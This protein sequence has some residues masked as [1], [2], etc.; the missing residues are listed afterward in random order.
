MKAI[1]LVI[2]ASLIMAK[3]FSS[4]SE[5]TIP[6]K[7][8]HVT[9]FL[10][11]AQII[12]EAEA[13]LP[14]GKSVLTVTGIS[15]FMDESSIQVGGQGAFT[16]L[17]VN[18]R[19]DFIQTL[20]DSPEV[21][22]LKKQIEELER[23]NEDEKVALEILRERESFLVTNK[24]IGG[25]EEALNPE[26]FRILFDLY[27]KNID[28]VKS[29]ILQ[30]QRAIKENDIV[31]AR[32][33]QQLAEYQNRKETPKSEIQITVSAKSAVN[34]KFRISYLVNG[35]GWFPSYDIRVEKLG[36]P[37]TL[38]YKANVSQ[39]TGVEWKNVLLT[40]SSAT[41]NKSGNVPILYPYFLD[42]VQVFNDRAYRSEAAQSKKV[43]TLD[44]S[45]ELPMMTSLAPEMTVGDKQTS[46]EFN[47]LV[48]YTIPSDSKSTSIDMQSFS[49]PSDFRYKAVPRLDPE[50]FLMA[51][52][53]D[54]EQYDL[55][56]GEA[57][58]YFENTFVGT[59]YIDTRS[60][61]DTLELSLG[62]DMGVVVKREKRKDFTSQRFFGNNKVETLSWEIS[63][64]NTKNEKIVI[65][66]TDQVPVSQQKDI[67][68]DVQELSGGKLDKDKGFVTWR[69]EL[70]AGQV[71][72]LVLTYEVRYPRDRVVVVE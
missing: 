27:G 36:D 49:L 26:S 19:R 13:S 23:K 22:E 16:I 28:L 38:V 43:M 10:Q 24:N 15:P 21:K 50:A 8:T 9:V 44:E 29:G 46:V 6:S 12:Q 2:A 58:L 1:T 62:R 5:K 51:R 63:V 47:M 48:P 72:N 57:N 18:Q 4:P 17:S 64:R 67:V 35:A 39:N 68:V 32:L 42:F 53:F 14:A 60:V 54:W 25:K 59:S 45:I 37:V 55:L 7:I 34:A 31:L 41:P 30:K 56:N 65:E 33:R 71:V 69:L 3:G 52:V 70:E 11:G 40:F 61:A 66:L 20:E